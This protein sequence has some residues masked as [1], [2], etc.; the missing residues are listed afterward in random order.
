MASI[1]KYVTSKGFNKN[2]F[3]EENTEID[4]TKFGKGFFPGNETLN[5]KEEE[6]EEVEE[7]EETTPTAP[8]TQT[9]P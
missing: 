4:I 2:I 8:E 6:V 7:V 5:P 1:A 9:E 3:L